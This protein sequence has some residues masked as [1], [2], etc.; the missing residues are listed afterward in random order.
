LI[1]AELT[2]PRVLLK[3]HDEL[4]RAPQRQWSTGIDGL[5]RVLD[6]AE[7]RHLHLAFL[8]AALPDKNPIYEHHVRGLELKLLHAGPQALTALEKRELLLNRDSIR[9]LRP[10][11][12]VEEQIDMAQPVS[13]S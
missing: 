7:I 12:A 4:A 6:D 11:P 5:A 8:P 1:H 9:R 3:V 10:E 13:N 2:P